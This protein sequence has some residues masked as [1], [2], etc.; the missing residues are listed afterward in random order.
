MLLLLCREFEMRHTELRCIARWFTYW[1][2]RVIIQEKIDIQLYTTTT[3]FMASNYIVRYIL[4]FSYLNK[5]LQKMKHHIF[6]WSLST[7]E[8]WHLWLHRLYTI[9]SRPRGGH[10]NTWNKLLFHY[11]SSAVYHCA[12]ELLALHFVLQ[13]KGQ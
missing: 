5:M 6:S 13:S 1:L 2:T 8:W 9:F 3:V 10:K 12:V 7:Y 4:I 11:G